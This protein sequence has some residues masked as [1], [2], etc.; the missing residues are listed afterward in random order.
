MPMLKRMLL[1]KKTDMC[2]RISPAG[3]RMLL[4][5]LLTGTS[6]LAAD[7][8]TEQWPQWRGPLRNGVA[9]SGDPPIAWSET[10]NVRWK[11]AIPGFGTSTPI[12]WENHVFIL[13]AIEAGQ[14]A[15]G[16]ALP[17]RPTSGGPGERSRGQ[18][19]G[20]G[21]G[22]E[23]PTAAARFLV[24]AYDRATGKVLWEQTAC[25]EVPQEG[26]HRDHGFASASPVTDG[27]HVY[28]YFG[29]R[30][31]YC[32]DFLGNLKWSKR[33]GKM[34]TR[35]AFG[36]GSSPA[37]HGDT[38]VILW[39]HEGDDFLVALDKRTGK[40]LW[41]QSRDEPTGWTTPLIVEHGD[42]TEVMVNATGKIR[43]YDFATGKLLWECAGMTGNPIPT[44]V[45]AK[46]LVWCTSG[47]RG[48]ALLAIKL[49]R[50]GDLA[51]TEAI[52]WQHNRN[53]PYV[54]SPLLYDGR[55]YFFSVN[56][57]LLSC[58]DARTGKPHYE[59]QRLTGI[60]GLYASPVGAAGRVY[61][62][63]RDGNCAVLKLGSTFELLSLNPLD[64][65][66]DAS[67]AVVGKELFLRGHRSL[68]CIAAAPS[69]M[70]NR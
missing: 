30:G 45:A 27:Q 14:S 42:R 56:N 5:I 68:Y 16:E 47:F 44:P 8:P 34:Q 50:T 48:S 32:Y 58:L 69:D 6:G 61:I 1:R 38:L 59:A 49:G 41:R 23:K 55:L 57:A 70:R 12:I 43:S 36:E 3:G 46:D 37:L 9:P 25:V 22:V 17:T 63:G 65:K 11:A 10:N 64:D 28:A 66:F 53:T 33:F 62:A 19:S 20:G 2:R 15:A 60:S 21:F 7:V 40:E 54:S 51:G 39:D 35:N 24:L 29:S 31:L 52:A 4:A 13:S 18:P 26:H 67:P